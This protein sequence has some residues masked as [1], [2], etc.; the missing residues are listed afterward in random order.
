[1]FRTMTTSK[2]FALSFFLILFSIT[3]FSQGRTSIRGKVVDAKTNSPIPGVNVFIKDMNVGAATDSI[4]NFSFSVTTGGTVTLQ[5]SIIGYNDYFTTFDLNTHTITHTIFLNDSHRTLDEVIVQSD[6]I[7]DRN[8]VSEVSLA[9]GK[10]AAKQGL[11]EDPLRAVSILPGVHKQGGDLFS[12]SQ[13]F[14]RGGAPDENIFLMDNTQIYWPWYQG[15]IRSIFNMETIREVELLTGGFSAKYGNALSSV[16]NV[17]TRDGNYENW[18]GNFSF[19]F[20]NAQSTIEGPLKKEKISFLLSARKTYLDLFLKPDK[21]SFPVSNLT[22]GTYKLAWKLN[23]KHKFT[24]SGLSSSE[25]TA[26]STSKPQLG[27]PNEIDTKGYKHT[28]SVQLHSNWSDQLY[29]KTSIVHSHSSSQV[30]VGRNMDFNIGGKDVGIREDF[31]YTFTNNATLLFGAEAHYTSFQTNGNSPLNPLEKDPSDT[32]VVLKYFNV[33]YDGWNGGTYL[34][35]SGIAMEKIGYS[36][37]YRYDYNLKSNTKNHSPR[38]SL[39]YSLANKIDIRATWGTFQQFPDLVAIDAQ[40]DLSSNRCYHYIFGVSKEIS[41]GIKTWAELYYKDY[42]NLVVQDGLDQYS[43]T[44]YGYS[45]GMEFSIQKESGIFTGWINYSFNQSKRY[46]PDYDK[47][48]T[49]D[50]GINHIFN[51]AIECHI[52]NFGKWYIP[53]LIA[54]QFRYNTGE[55]YTPVSSAI[56]TSTG[57]QK[58][59]G[60]YNAQLRG[61]F[62][63]LSLR[64]EWRVYMNRK[65]TMRMTSFFEFWNLYNHLNEL[66]RVHQY[67]SEYPNN[68]EETIYYSTPFLNA[69]GFKISF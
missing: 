18:H 35:Y 33:N 16:M 52:N 23:E 29:G 64:V 8:S 66:G 25:G 58:V 19:G 12:P 9:P 32:N 55:P 53:A 51:M 37:G 56:Q 22:D 34:T 14:V 54:T 13:I 2:P 46:H 7:I 1:M 26:Y 21:A 5:A 63:N 50:F 30:L 57:W 11:W 42:H 27:I 47:L 15:G 36:L 40:K 3:A 39:N 31:T 61:D 67:G 28:Q 65:R 45:R 41:N 10:I 68:I 43:N 20:A 44:G 59:Y 48:L 4:G 6:R 24:F 17:S 69:G 60:E 49:A 38:L 62:H